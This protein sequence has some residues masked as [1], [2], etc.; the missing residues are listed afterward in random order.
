[1]DKI[2]YK[3]SG[4]CA[5]KNEYFE[6]VK[7]QKR[8]KER[9]LRPILLFCGLMSI[10]FCIYDIFIDES[11]MAMLSAGFAFLLLYP[12]TFSYVFDAQKL[13]DTDKNRVLYVTMSYVFYDNRFSVT[14]R[15]KESFHSYSKINDIRMTR[16]KLYF[17]TDDN[18]YYI[19]K[20]RLEGV[21]L[22]EIKKFLGKM[23][24]K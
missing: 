1:M 2:V 12:T 20:K 10:A 22:K 3:A 8:H 15:D 16:R 17:F 6:F 5:D 24:K 23:R 18:V 7:I 21:T 19:D 14:M 9:R 13:Y 11:I 4:V